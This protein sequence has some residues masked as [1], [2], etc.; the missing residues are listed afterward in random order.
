M[1]VRSG[2]WPHRAWRRGARARRRAGGFGPSALPRLSAAARPA[3]SPLVTRA[4]IALCI[5]GLFFMIKESNLPIRDQVLRFAGSLL[6]TDYDLREALQ[7][8]RAVPVL[9]RWVRGIESRVTEGRQ[10]GS[11]GPGSPDGGA[12][13]ASMGAMSWPVEGAIA[14][15]FGWAPEPGANREV[16]HEGVDIEAPEGTLVRAALDGT[17]AEVQ[18]SRVYGNAILIDHGD[19]VAT[20]YGHCRDVWVARRQQVRRGDPIASVGKTGLTGSPLLHFEVRVGGVPQDPCAWIGA[21]ERI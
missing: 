2:L 9:G 1:P 16:F 15:G 13:G 21:G 11:A 10:P 8:A 17:V 19:G 4:V 12:R 18:E 20:F 3:D 7:R 5:F 6:S 14:A